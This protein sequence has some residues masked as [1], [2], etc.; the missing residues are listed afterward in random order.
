MVF[1]CIACNVFNWRL[2][3]TVS[4]ISGALALH[5]LY[6]YNKHSQ[7]EYNVPS[8]YT[9]SDSQNKRIK[10]NYQRELLDTSVQYTCVSASQ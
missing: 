9:H 5:A 4:D 7:S 8:I 3:T 6:I 1:K 2:L 10:I